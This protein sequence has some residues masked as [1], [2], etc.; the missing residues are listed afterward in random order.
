MSGGKV[1]SAENKTVSR[2]TEG[3]SVSHQCK[4]Q[5]GKPK[6]E[7][8]ATSLF[9]L[10]S[11][12]GSCMTS[13]KPSGCHCNNMVNFDPSDPR[14]HN[15]SGPHETTDSFSVAEPLDD[16][17]IC[18]SDLPPLC[19][20][21]CLD[22]VTTSPARRRLRNTPS[23]GLDTLVTFFM[24][25]GEKI[26]CADFVE[27]FF[28]F[29]QSVGLLMQTQRE[30]D[31]K[32]GHMHQGLNGDSDQHNS[33]KSMLGDKRNVTPLMCLPVMEAR[34]AAAHTFL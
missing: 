6:K 5:K 28:F 18:R 16:G 20:N 25:L 7:N 19:S 33:I 26:P 14:H 10:P 8:T 12:A 32:L 17:H 23:H 22:S 30:R 31:Q 3:G 1:S 11:T 24:W 4:L 29:I 34:G 21:T 2:Q 27:F 15:I 9:F 13:L